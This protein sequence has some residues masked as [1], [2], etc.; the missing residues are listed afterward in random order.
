MV[1]SQNKKKPVSSPNFKSKLAI[2]SEYKKTASS[3]VELNLTIPTSVID[4]TYQDTLA[5]LAKDVEIKGFRKGSAPLKLVEEKLGRNYVLKRASESIILL[6]YV[7]AIQ[8]QKLSPIADPKLIKALTPEKGEWSLTFNVPLM[9]QVELPKDY[10]YQIAKKVKAEPEIITPDKATDKGKSDE[11]KKVD[12][13]NKI[14]IALLEIGKLELPPML[15]ETEVNKRL[16]SLVDQVQKLQMTMDD[17]LKSKGLTSEKV[18]Q[19][20]QKQVEEELKL[21]FIL[22]QVGQREKIQ[23]SQAELDAIMS[24]QNKQPVD[25][26]QR[27]Q[28]RLYF[29]SLLLRNKVVAFLLDKVDKQEVIVRA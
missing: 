22:G 26:R 14:L 18:R 28:E 4:Q 25:K 10:I 29:Q 3:Q 11:Q 24:K 8:T 15:I 5:F 2:K 27:E 20:I 16:S 13:L 17:Y 23:V 12:K 7:Q 19:S 1:Q 6:A 9:P 21:D